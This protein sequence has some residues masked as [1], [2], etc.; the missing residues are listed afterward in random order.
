MSV[1]KSRAEARA[2]RVQ[3]AKLIKALVDEM[4]EALVEMGGSGHRDAVIAR[5]AVRLGVS[6]ATEDFKRDVKEAFE[7]RRAGPAD[8]GGGALLCLPFGEG[9]HRWALTA[10]ARQQADERARDEHPIGMAGPFEMASAA[11]G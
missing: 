9:S 1:L 6:P 2:I 8:E 3:R 11:V 10:Y 5:V 7:K 4:V